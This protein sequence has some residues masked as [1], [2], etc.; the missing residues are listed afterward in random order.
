MNL[1]S[2]FSFS[3]LIKLYL[4]PQC[5]NNVKLEHAVISIKYIAS[6]VSLIFAP[7]TLI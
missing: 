6:V 1:C 2:I 7:K 3:I 5:I 4:F